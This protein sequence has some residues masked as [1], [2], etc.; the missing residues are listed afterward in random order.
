MTYARGELLFCTKVVKNL[1]ISKKNST[2]ASVMRYTFLFLCAFVLL[3]CNRPSRVEQ[4]KADK[5]RSDSIHLVEQTTSLAYYQ[6]QLESLMPKAD[7]L[8]PYFKYEK[9]EKYQDHGFYVVNGKQGL[10]VKVRDDGKEPIL[11]YRDGKRL[12]TTDDPVYERAEH[13]RIVIADIKECEKRI[14]RT[15]LE[16]QKYEKR[17]QKQ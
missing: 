15:S 10:R 8:L 7:S 13:L 14:A 4:Y 5:H 11:L 3:A 17:L 9:N 2:F 16:V 6:S 12:V 1:R